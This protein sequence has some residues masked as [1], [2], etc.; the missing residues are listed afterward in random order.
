MSQQ[1]FQPSFPKE[2]LSINSI[3]LWTYS[4]SGATLVSLA[5]TLSISLPLKD[6][7]YYANYRV[8]Q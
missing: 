6:V 7:S 5:V 2:T 4:V 3:L 8:T 1:L